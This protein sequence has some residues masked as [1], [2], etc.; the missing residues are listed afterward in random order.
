MNDA[1]SI[2]FQ[3]L[4]NDNMLTNDEGLQL[5]VTGVSNIVGGVVNFQPNGDFLYVPFNDF[6]GTGSFN[7]AVADACGN[8]STA[9]VTVEVGEPDCTFTVIFSME[10]AECGLPTGSL[11]A[12][13]SPDDV[14]TFQWSNGA[15]SPQMISPTKGPSWYRGYFQDDLSQG[16][17][18]ATLR[19]FNAN[20]VV[21]GHTLQRKVKKMYNGKVFA[22]DVN[23]PKDYRKSWPHQE[24]EGLLIQDGKYYRLLHDGTEIEL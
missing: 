20:T 5:Q 7:Y 21:V 10:A 4:V 14:Y 1:Y 2:A 17:V 13:P 24:S 9:S 8:T 22:I 16:D 12:T 11:L 23:H 19:A 15:T 3:N 6:T 18:E